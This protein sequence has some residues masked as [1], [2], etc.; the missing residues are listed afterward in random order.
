[1]HAAQHPNRSRLFRFITIAASGLGSFVLGLW[2]LK[3]GFGDGLGGMSAQV[4]ASLCALAA[5]A[6][7]AAFFAGVDESASYVFNETQIDKLTGLNG[8]TAMIGKI[9]EAAAASIRTGEPSFLIDIDIDRFKQINDAIGYTQGDELISAFAAR[10]KSQLP[11]TAV[12][13]RIGAG[14]FAVLYH[15]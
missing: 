7:A 11:D 5:A 13:G 3:L 9:A 12:I 1:M 14:E 6:A 2:G 4:I 15:Y 10:L 8:R